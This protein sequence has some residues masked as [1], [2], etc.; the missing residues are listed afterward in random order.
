MGQFQWKLIIDYLPRFKDAFITTVFLFLAVLVITTAIGLFLAVLNRIV[1]SKF[2]LGRLLINGYSWLFR[3]LPELIV[4]LFCY[5]GL[6]LMGFN[7]NPIPAAILGFS[8]PGVAYL[9]EIFNAGFSGV[10]SGQYM[11]CR[12]LG[13][14]MGHTLI[15]IIFP[16][17]IRIIIPSY[18]TYMTGAS[19][20]TSAASAIA[21]TEIMGMA[22]KIMQATLR[23]FESIFIAMVL[24]ALISSVF[25]IIEIL[26]QKK[27]VKYT[28]ASQ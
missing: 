28:G 12:A 6:P 16:Q 1:F 7:I 10:D 25:M 20:R 15:K 4:L 2:K 17:V 19:K 18:T 27:S 26:A 21:V 5:L 23:P 8:I 9:Y 13:M 24:Y 11:A 14:P 22:K 3:S